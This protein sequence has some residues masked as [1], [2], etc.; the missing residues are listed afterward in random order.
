MKHV[1][2]FQDPYSDTLLAISSFDRSKL[3]FCY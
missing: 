2:K 3:H 1:K